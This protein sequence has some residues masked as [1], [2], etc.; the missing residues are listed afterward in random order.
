MNCAYLGIY[1]YMNNFIHYGNECKITI[2]ALKEWQWENSFMSMYNQKY[3]S[4]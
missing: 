3:P 1:V 2:I 4:D